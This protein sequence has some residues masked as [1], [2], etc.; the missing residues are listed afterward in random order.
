MREEIK[1]AARSSLLAYAKWNWREYQI[2]KHT[3]I[4]ADALEAVERGE[5]TRLIIEAPPRHGKT[6]LVSETFPAWFLGK[7]PTKEVIF[8]T[9]S[10]KL[11]NKSGRR[12]RNQLLNSGF[13]EIFPESR[14]S[15][16]SKS[17]SDFVLIAV[18]DL[19]PDVACDRQGAWVRLG[20]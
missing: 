9:Y 7:N 19:G 20:R 4:I 8:S 13:T 5:I 15:M 6:Y 14:V 2:A 1:I 11:A 17:K 16:D 10:Q 18:G 12:V 3:K